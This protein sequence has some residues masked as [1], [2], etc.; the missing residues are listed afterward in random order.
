MKRLLGLCLLLLAMPAGALERVVSLSPALNELML[1]LGAGPQLVGVL[2]TRE[3]PAALA[4]LPSVGEYG[5]LEIETLL[6]LKPQ[7]VLLW[8]D[9][10]GA[11]QR[12][13]LRQL[14]LELYE[15]QPHSLDELATQVE[16]LALRVG[17]AERGLQLAQEFRQ[18]LAHLRQRYQRQPPL[19]VFYQVWDSPLY[20]IGGQQ[21]ISDALRVCGAENLLSDLTLAAPQI[22]LETVLARD[23]EVILT[24]EPQLLAAWQ[25]W[26]QLQAV[27]RGQVWSIPDRGLERPSL[28][29]LNATERLCE[30]LQS[31]H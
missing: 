19:R 9:S 14:G 24:S 26:P 2:G 5:Q 17:R 1:E 6:S 23:P 28:Q 4:D 12:Q 15:V 3:R 16:A 8:P 11:A 29:M 18:Q 25:A 7:L 30:L 21:I 27:K 10:I 22:N 20:S 31:A 13:Q